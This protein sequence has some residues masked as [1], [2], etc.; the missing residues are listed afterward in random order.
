MFT[1][2][3]LM[4][5]FKQNKKINFHICTNIP[6]SGGINGVLY[7]SYYGNCNG[8]S[9]NIKGFA[10][11]YIVIERTNEQGVVLRTIYVLYESITKVGFF[12]DK[13]NPIYEFKGKV[14]LKEI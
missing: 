14:N 6:T 4:D 13:R 8:E 10:D 7:D 12:A 3:I 1:K 9:H 5:L 11:S 2:E